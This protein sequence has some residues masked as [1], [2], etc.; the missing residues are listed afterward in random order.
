MRRYINFV[1]ENCRFPS[2][3][4]PLSD[5]ESTLYYWWRDRKTGKF[6]IKKEVITELKNSFLPDNLFEL[7]LKFFNVYAKFFSELKE[8]VTENNRLPKAYSR[9]KKEQK[10]YHW[11]TSRKKAGKNN[12]WKPILLHILKYNDIK[13]E[14]F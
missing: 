5:E 1:L 2:G 10:L 6:S 3:K 8:F 9:A 12:I 7:N 4:F 11:L 14:K 13:M